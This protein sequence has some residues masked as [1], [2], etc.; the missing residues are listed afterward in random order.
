[1]TDFD[2]QRREGRRRGTLFG[3]VYLV[4]LTGPIVAEVTSRRPPATKAAAMVVLAAFMALNLLFWMRYAFEPRVRP[5]ALVVLGAMCGITVG[6]T[7]HDANWVWCFVY[8]AV[9]AGASSWDRRRGG[10]LVAGVVALALALA[11]VDHATWDQI[12]V[13]ALICLMGGIGM[14]G[15]SR[16][17]QAVVVERQAREEVGRL[18]VAEERLRFARDL[19][20]LL[21]HSLSVVILKSELAARLNADAPERAVQEM[22]DVER[23]AREALREVRE[24]VAGY[25]QLGLSQQLESVRATLDA[26]GIE[27]R[28]QSTAGALPTPVDSTLAWA[29][30]EGVTNILRH[31]RAGHVEAR[32]TRAEERAE[33]ELLDDGIGCDDCGD[34]NGLR[35]LRERVA[36]RNGR[37]EAGPRP[38]GGFRLAVSL[39]VQ[40]VPSTVSAPV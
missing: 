8:C 23:V 15:T 28:L 3:A 14:I 33:L 26:A 12:L 11:V 13:V 30:R 21:G 4:F 17:I 22:R 7:L 20:E 16:L 37:L 25:R 6:L 31:S 32:V 36:A 24:A 29:L 9:V 38:E 40:D 18:A 5:A 34:G 39:P 19:H 1:M 35:G 2:E 27:A 10:L